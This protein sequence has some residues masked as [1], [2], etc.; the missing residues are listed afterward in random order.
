M[1]FF[2]F[3][4]CSAL[5]FLPHFIY[6]KATPLSDYDTFTTSAK[7]AAVYIATALLKLICQATFL[8]VQDADVFD[9]NQEILKGLIGFLDIVG[10]YFALTQ[11][12]YRNISQNHK[13]QAVGLGWAFADSVLHRAVPLWVNARK[14]ES[15]W[16]DLLQG[17]EANA[18]LVFNLSLAALASLI[19]LRK[20]KPAGLLPILYTFAGVHAALPVVLSYLRLG[21]VTD[22]VSVVGFEIA[23]VVVLAIISWRLFVLCSYRNSA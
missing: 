18:N 21:K 17:F 10:I 20:S 5:T 6:Y 11:L 1:T 14:A 15:S 13:F 16:D 12:Q 19:W 2:H 8:R 3:I 7:A 22:G 4:N 23:A 9:L